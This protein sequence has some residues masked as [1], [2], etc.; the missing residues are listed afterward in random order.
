M[1]ALREAMEILQ[2]RLSEP[3]ESRHVHPV[4][5]NEALFALTS[6]PEIKVP[7]SE[8]RAMIYAA[9]KP[10]GQL[11]DFLRVASVSSYELAEIAFQGFDGQRITVPFT[12]LRGLI[13]RIAHIVALSEDL[14]PLSESILPPK[15]PWEPLFGVRDRIA[16]ALLGTQRDWLKLAESDFRQTAS[17]DL[18][19]ANRDDR[20]DLRARSILTAVGNLEKRIPGSRLAY[21]VLCEFLHPNIGDMVGATL[22]IDLHTDQHGTIHIIKNYGLGPK[23]Q[24]DLAPIMVK[25]LSVCRDIVRYI[26]IA[27][28]EIETISKSASFMAKKYAHP[29]VKRGRHLFANE[30]R[31]PC[32]SGLTVKACFRR[33][34]GRI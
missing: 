6:N 3:Y 30:D 31:C 10:A 27:F 16:R 25:L 23:E 4:Q 9:T 7:P 1:S 19:Y 32:H 29:M 28:A 22:A 34:I 13:E 14:R 17:E 12:A 21:D 18:K 20:A 15:K 5:A 8:Y 24:R 33:A 2:R 11:A 26:P